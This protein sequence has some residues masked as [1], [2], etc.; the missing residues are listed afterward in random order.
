MLSTRSIEEAEREPQGR[1]AK[2]HYP[3]RRKP[4]GRLD[5]V[6]GAAHLHLNESLTRTRALD[7]LEATVDESVPSGR[8]ASGASKRSEQIESEQP[9]SRSTPGP[10][11]GLHDSKLV[12][13]SRRRTA[14][15][16]RKARAH[17]KRTPSRL[18]RDA[19]AGRSAERARSAALLPRRS[20]SD[21]KRE[22]MPLR[23][24]ER[25][26][27]QTAGVRRAGASERGDRGAGAS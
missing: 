4:S 15:S 16:Q 23:R 19:G 20:R 5:P 24:A 17:V 6:H 1:R 11:A 8:R 21:S 12:Q 14:G 27:E 10:P 3:S 13:A 18:Q 26:I 2:R 25:T 9:K 22:T 7:R